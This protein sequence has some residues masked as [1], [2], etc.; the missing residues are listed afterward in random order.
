MKKIED[1]GEVIP[2]A[3][4]DLYKIRGILL[5]DLYDIPSSEYDTLMRRDIIWPEDDYVKMV[6][7]QGYEP[8]ATYAIRT[9]RRMLPTKA[10]FTGRGDPEDTAMK[11]VAFIQWCRQTMM[12]LKHIDDIETVVNKLSNVYHGAKETVIEPD[13]M[14][15]VPVRVPD[16]VS[17]RD[18]YKI[19]DVARNVGA[20]KMECAIQGWPEHFSGDLRG[21]RFRLRHGKYKLYSSKG[22][23]MTT[24]E[25]DSME[26]GIAWVRAGNLQEE[27]SDSK[28]RKKV[29]N[30]VTVVRPQ[31]EYIERVGPNLRKGRDAGPNH[32]LKQFE[33]RGGQFGN[34]NSPGDRQACLNYAFDGLVDM[35]Y[36]LNVPTTFFSLERADGLRL[37]IA[38]G[39]RG[40]SR[41]SAH[42]EPEL[43]VINLTKMYG[44][45]S[46]AHELG[47]AIDYWL[48]DEFDEELPGSAEAKIKKTSAVE[49]VNRTS[50]TADEAYENP[51]I[52]VLKA[53]KMIVVNMQKTDLPL[54]KPDFV[55]YCKGKF[56]R[57]GVS[58]GM[59]GMNLRTFSSDI[60]RG[61]E[62]RA[63]ET[64]D[65]YKRAVEIMRL[66]NGAADE[67]GEARGKRSL[68]DIDAAI[69]SG[70]SS[71]FRGV[72]LEG[73]DRNDWFAGYCTPA[74]AQDFLDNWLNPL[75]YQEDRKE[76]LWDKMYEFS[77]GIQLGVVA[78]TGE[79]AFTKLIELYEIPMKY[80]EKFVQI[81]R[82]R[83]VKPDKE[84]AVQDDGIPVCE[85]I[86]SMED[87]YCEL[88]NGDWR[89]GDI[90][91]LLEWQETASDSGLYPVNTLVSSEE[92]VR[93]SQFRQDA[94]NLDMNR[95][96]PYYASLKEMFARAFEHYIERR[97]TEQGLR[98]QYLVH[99]TTNKCYEDLP[100]PL[101]PYPSG[102][103]SD[104]LCELFDRLFK[105]IID[106]GMTGCEVFGYSG[107]YSD[108]SKFVSYRQ[109]IK[110]VTKREA[111]ELEDSGEKQAATVDKPTEVTGRTEFKP[112]KR[113]TAKPASTGGANGA[114]GGLP[115]FVEKRARDLRV[116]PSAAMNSIATKCR[117][118]YGISCGFVDKLPEAWKDKTHSHAVYV[119][120]A[121]GT[122][123][124]CVLRSVPQTKQLEALIEGTVKLWANRFYNGKPIG[125]VV[126]LSLYI[127]CR[128]YGLDIRTY[129]ITAYYQLAEQKPKAA[130]ELM[131]KT[132]E[133]LQS[134]FINAIF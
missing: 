38:F 46:L 114:S 79:S 120:Q 27:L 103:E 58:L 98:S 49:R 127:L 91:R 61:M 56:I 88:M 83:A 70:V 113:E 40:H 124:V 107:L 48:A 29:S 117:T 108:T 94:E 111:A 39:A 69:E 97:L 106:C 8:E 133:F 28:S 43:H 53:L 62:K 119:E 123:R 54:R 30:V 22:E 75:F 99:S 1:F 32:I 82:R 89:Y 116:S 80:I 17:W 85:R 10:V 4:K 6:N 36:V 73:L 115:T 14:V 101:S 9:I 37:G 86:N 132:D 20:L 24:K 15:E 109:N 63:S 128:R 118:Q 112:I 12:E 18:R 100:T 34:W 76:N 57:F 25:F 35:A 81:T 129:N 71:H 78:S 64:E 60:K 33:F 74:E 84:T 131:S 72:S 44:A 55:K 105:T 47:H 66:A 31:L 45:G 52:R 121:G 50:F 122:W 102:L 87:I 126:N 19:E 5:S 96:V 26:E 23:P 65:Q 59:Y 11:Y 67:N 93:K 42:Y 77:R 95:R 51:N 90:K 110:T 125:P 7:E 16:S 104:R 3:R 41:A 130:D 68:S 134:Q 13:T 2:G 92:T 21:A